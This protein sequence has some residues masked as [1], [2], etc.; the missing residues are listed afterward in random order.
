MSRETNEWLNQNI[1]IG[2]EGRRGKAWWY[3]ASNEGAEPNHY[4][5]AIPMD[6]VQRR[7]FNWDPI[8]M[9]V[10]I[11][12]VRNGELTD[13]YLDVPDKKAVV[14]SD[15]PTHVF[16]IFSEGYVAHSY[17]EW[18][19]KNVAHIL[20]GD[21]A[22]SSAGL[23]K[24][25]AVAWVEISV[26]DTI[27]TNHGVDFRP[28]LLAT[29]SLD[30]TVQT[31]YKRTCTMTVCDNT[32]GMAMA[33]QGQ[34]YKVKHSK[35]SALKKL[36]AIDA[37]DIVHSMADDIAAELD[38]LC[39]IDVTD[40]EF[41]K[42]VENVV[43]L[44]ENGTKQGIFLAERKRGELL[45]LWTSDDRVSRWQNTGFAAIQAFNTWAHHLKA[46]RGDTQ[47]AERNMLGAINGTFEKED[48][49]IV[50]VMRKLDLLP[51]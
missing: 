38:A 17:E 39:E 16:G 3:R 12:V 25:R 26:A 37:L 33:E 32:Y 50:D 9:P 44:D 45:K 5:E 43:P 28:N 10:A 8:E 15:D 42:I 1:L 35:Y 46:T 40:E 29:T 11:P 20:D 36:D 13:E 6:D 22:I 49:K 34:T 51:V 18:L 31:T 24:K 41:R 7:L 47:L 19:V 2:F 4:A 48:A 14:P 27:H 23:L 30:G 21:L